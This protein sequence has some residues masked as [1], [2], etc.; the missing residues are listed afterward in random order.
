MFDGNTWS[1]S[2]KACQLKSMSDEKMGLKSVPKIGHV[3][4]IFSARRFR[5]ILRIGN[6]GRTLGGFM[7]DLFFFGAWESLMIVK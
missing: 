6:P 5:W 2:L 4:S 3:S 7:A 1:E